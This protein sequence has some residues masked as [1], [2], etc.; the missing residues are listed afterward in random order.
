MTVIVSVKT[1]D[2]VVM[3]SDSAT[4][5]ANGQIYQHASKIVNLI[6]DLPIGVM[7]AGAG[8]IGSESVATLFKDLRRR[9]DGS[10]PH[11]ADKPF[12]RVNYTVAE[13]ATAVRRFLFEEKA[14]EG[15]GAVWQP[16]MAMKVR[17]CG[18]SAGRPLPEVWEIAMEGS[19]CP[20]PVLIQGEE[21]CGPRWDGQYEALNRLI[22]GYGMALAPTLIGLGITAQQVQ[23]IGP[24]LNA[25]MS[26]L[27]VLPAMP[28]QDA[29]DLAR[30]L[31]ET[32]IGFVRFSVRTQ[33]KIVG[34]PIEIAAITKHEGF[35][36]VQRKHFYPTALNP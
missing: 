24:G 12:D 21:S 22:I 8:Q 28:I 14:L 20:D 1:N 33:P 15:K 5:F 13:L 6:K 9:L 36:W 32:T 29:I 2:G 31:V 34:G 23:E 27:F 18:Y 19:Q 11:T 17:V 35:R 16:G 3:A 7:V 25:A 10:N 4:T 26:E 30:F